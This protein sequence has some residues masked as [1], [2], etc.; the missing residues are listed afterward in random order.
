LNIPASAN[1]AMTPVI[2][3]VT[4]GWNT[5]SGSSKYPTTVSYTFRY[6]SSVIDLE[7]ETADDL[8]GDTAILNSIQAQ[9]APLTLTGANTDTQWQGTANV[10]AAAV[11]ASN[12]VTVSIGTYTYNPVISGGMDTSLMSG[13]NPAAAVVTF[14]GGAVG[15]W[16]FSLIHPTTPTLVITITTGGTITDLRLVGKAFSASNTPITASASDAA[17]IA[18]YDKRNYPISNNYLINSGIA[19]S[20]ANRLLSNFKSPTVYIKNLRVQPTWSI[21]TGDRCTVVDD[22]S[23]IN[24]DYIVVEI[25]Q[26]LASGSG[27]AQ[28]YTELKLM[29]VV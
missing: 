23:G 13:A 16:A 25:K 24:T 1:G 14:G 3:D 12:P 5:G 18:L 9:S 17:S 11:S 6:D 20:V 26:V 28:A 2:Y 4:V 21:Q 27:M 19:Q 8:G 29:L 22:N 7:E 10:P 15:S